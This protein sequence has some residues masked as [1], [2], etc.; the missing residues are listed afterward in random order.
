MNAHWIFKLYKCEDETYTSLTCFCS[1]CCCNPL[2][3][4][5]FYP[6]EECYCH[7]CGAHMTEEPE[8]MFEDEKTM[9]NAY[10][11]E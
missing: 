5:T 11:W 10:K 9:Y 3:R 2:N 8:F 1:N 6:S 7:S 4:G